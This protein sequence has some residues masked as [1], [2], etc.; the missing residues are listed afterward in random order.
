MAIWLG[1]HYPSDWG[2]VNQPAN[3]MFILNPTLMHADFTVF[4]VDVDQ[5]FEGLLRPGEA[6]GSLK[7]KHCNLQYWHSRFLSLPSE[8]RT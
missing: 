5:R 8:H 2:G 6:V 7:V 3:K 1:P 4:L